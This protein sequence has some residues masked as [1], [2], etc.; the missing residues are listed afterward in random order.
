MQV[1]TAKVFTFERY[2]IEPDRSLASLRNSLSYRLPQTFLTPG[3]KLCLPCV[4]AY[5]LREVKQ[6]QKARL[7]DCKG[8]IKAVPL[9]DQTQ[10]QVLVGRQSGKR[11]AVV[12]WKGKL[13]RLKGCGNLNEGFP[14]REMVSEVSGLVE[15]RGCM[16]EQTVRRELYITDQ[17]NHILESYKLKGANQS[18]GYWEY[19]SVQNINQHLSEPLQNSFQIVP[20]YCGIYETLGDQRL[21]THLL[22]GL[23]VIIARLLQSWTFDAVLKL[24]THPERIIKR[25]DGSL[26]LVNTQFRERD[27]SLEDCAKGSLKEAL[28]QDQVFDW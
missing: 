23:R 16:F 17:V 4:P 25:P 28:Q 9:P 21:G 10:L 14:S 13:Y 6:A 11:S 3:T 26:D 20:K 24:I 5:S 18:A 1:P 7:F 22:Q 15:I 19:A 2:S 8:F 12:E 27:L